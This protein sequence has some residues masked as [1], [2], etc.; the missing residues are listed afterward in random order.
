MANNIDH[1]TRLLSTPVSVHRKQVDNGTSLE[2]Q[3]EQL[4]AFARV[5]N[6]RYS[7]NILTRVF[8]ARMI[9]ALASNLYVVMQG[10][11][12]E[13]VIVWRLDRLARNLRLILGIEAELREQKVAVFSMKEMVDT[14]TSIGRTVF[15]VLGLTAEWERDSIIERTKL[16]V[17]SDRKKGIGL[18]ALLPLDMTITGTPRIL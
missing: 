8:P 17:F 14:S 6:G 10:W 5:K 12:F 3:S 7:T 18:V 16:A 4:E 9:T 15:Q 2:S 1:I 11:L 13:K